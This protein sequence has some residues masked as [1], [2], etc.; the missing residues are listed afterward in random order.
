MKPT[1]ESSGDV[2]IEYP[3]EGTDIAH[4]YSNNYVRAANVENGVG[5]LTGGQTLS[6]N[7][8]NNWMLGNAGNDTLI[9][10]LGNDTLNGGAGN[11]TLI[12]GLG[13]DQYVVDSTGD[14]IIEQ[15]GEG[16]DAAY[17]L[18]SVYTLADHVER[19]DR[20]TTGATLTG[21]ADSNA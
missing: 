6:G 14:V 2:L 4:A 16:T 8:G 9:G 7:D 13:N 15:A 3:N 21:N 20:I 5:E 10:G 11:D 12:G 19:S 18:T 17:V 1:T